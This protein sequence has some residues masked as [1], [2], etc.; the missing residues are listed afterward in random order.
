MPTFNFWVYWQWSDKH[1]P[2]KIVALNFAFTWKKQ[3]I[4]A[5]K[6]ELQGKDMFLTKDIDAY[7]DIRPENLC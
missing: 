4:Y 6:S 7:L 3:E 2:K 1:P 5:A